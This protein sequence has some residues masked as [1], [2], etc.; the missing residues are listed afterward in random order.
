VAAFNSRLVPSA[1]LRPWFTTAM[2]RASWSASS[3]YC[4]VRRTVT[5]EAASR[6]IS[7][8]TFCRAVG[9]SPVVGSSRNSTPGVTTSEAAMSSR[10]RMPPE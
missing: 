10:R 4:V 7:R 3:R 2:R 9:S 6:R 1:I 8:Q 5:P